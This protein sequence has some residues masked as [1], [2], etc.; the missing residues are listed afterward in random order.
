MCLIYHIAINNLLENITMKFKNICFVAATFIGV[1]SCQPIDQSKTENK[2]DGKIQ[3]KSSTI[4]PKIP[5]RESASLE[6][7]RFNFHKGERYSVSSVFGLPDYSFSMFDFELLIDEEIRSNTASKLT[8][9]NSEFGLRSQYSPTQQLAQYCMNHGVF[10]VSGTNLKTA[11]LEKEKAIRLCLKEAL[12]QP[13]SAVNLAEIN[14]SDLFKVARIDR[15][16]NLLLTNILEDKNVS[17]SEYFTILDRL[18]AYKDSVLK[19]AEREETFNIMRSWQQ[20]PPQ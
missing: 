8:Q 10:L 17:V 12:K 5:L 13:I 6:E 11:R 3:I 2:Y 7:E 15:D 9:L 14:N 19:G 16:F 1:T 4:V 18:M 20:Q